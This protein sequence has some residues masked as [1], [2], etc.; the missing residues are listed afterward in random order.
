MKK[1]WEWMEEKEYGYID[2]D[3]VDKPEPTITHGGRCIANIP[4]QM[5]IGYMMEYL[6][7]DCKCSYDWNDIED[8]HKTIDETYEWL[9]SNIEETGLVMQLLI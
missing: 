4:Y 6:I 5:L 1:F 3:W 7:F 8:R 9:K 2:K